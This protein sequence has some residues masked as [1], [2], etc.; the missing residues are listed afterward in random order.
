MIM[1]G[2]RTGSIRSGQDNMNTM[3]PHRCG[4]SPEVG[5]LVHRTACHMLHT[6]GGL[7]P[8]GRIWVP[9]FTASFLARSESDVASLSAN[10]E[11]SHPVVDVRLPSYNDDRPRDHGYV[12]DNST[13]RFL[14]VYILATLE[15]SRAL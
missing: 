8:R 3:I 2:Y 14:G 15:T 10:Y 6:V 5:L 11:M 7:Y 4:S 13:I 9:A 1:R 12:T